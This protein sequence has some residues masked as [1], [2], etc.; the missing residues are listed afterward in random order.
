[1]AQNIINYDHY[2]C[3]YQCQGVIFINTAQKDS[4]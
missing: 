1:M 2:S 4:G 3:Q